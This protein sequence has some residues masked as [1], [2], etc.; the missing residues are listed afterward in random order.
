MN[1]S[2]PHIRNPIPFNVM[3]LFHFSYVISVLGSQLAS[4]P[5]MVVCSQPFSFFLYLFLC[6]L[7]C[8]C[9]FFSLLYNLTPPYW[10]YEHCVNCGFL[11][12]HF[13][14]IDLGEKGKFV[15]RLIPSMEEVYW[16]EVFFL[17]GGGRWGWQ[18][19]IINWDAQSMEI[20]LSFSMP[21]QR[22]TLSLGLETN[23]LPTEYIKVLNHKKGVLFYHVTNS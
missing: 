13:V 19:K 9:F 14:H 16:H 23:V 17:G 6:C 18:Q 8:F 15:E 3:I 2:E 5:S 22:R 4:S 12:S 11:F 21:G 7:C 1:L 20:F 10:I